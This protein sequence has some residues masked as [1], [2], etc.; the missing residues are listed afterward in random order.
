MKKLLYK[1]WFFSHSTLAFNIKEALF[2]DITVCVG[3]TG[4]LKSCGLWLSIH[5]FLKF[6]FR[7]RCN[8]LSIYVNSAKIEGFNNKTEKIVH[9]KWIN[10]WIIHLLSDLLTQ[11][12]ILYTFFKYVNH[13]HKY[14]KPLNL[15]SYL[16]SQNKTEKY[17]D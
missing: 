3:P 4:I 13:A 12:L 1:I 11:W 14:L 17:I 6:L 15:S 9:S 5:E 8:F 7:K 10:T 16:L 2:C